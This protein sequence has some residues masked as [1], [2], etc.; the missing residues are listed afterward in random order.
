MKRR[1]IFIV[2]IYVCYSFVQAKAADMCGRKG[3]MVDIV[4]EMQKPS[5]QT[6][7]RDH[8][9]FINKDISDGSL[10]AFSM[11]NT[12]VHPSAV[13]R[14]A[15]KEGHTSN[16]EVGILCSLNEKACN[17]FKVQALEKMNKVEI[18]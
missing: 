5:V 7:W 2:I 18:N 8:K 4:L 6:V 11:P 12:T 14:R 9:L 1:T 15:I 10:W 3:N 17:S 16:A 13:C